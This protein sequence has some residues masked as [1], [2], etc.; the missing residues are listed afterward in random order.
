MAGTDKQFTMC[1]VYNSPK[2]LFHQASCTTYCSQMLVDKQID[3]E[4]CVEAR[5]FCQ[6]LME[7]YVTLLD[8][9]TYMP[10]EHI[11]KEKE[12]GIPWRTTFKQEVLALANETHRKLVGEDA[13][14]F[15]A[16]SEDPFLFYHQIVKKETLD[17]AT[18]DAKS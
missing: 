14:G 8:N 9:A 17:A 3:R 2:E 13:G 10:I 11:Q 6:Q 1:D 4:K 15:Q 16:N 7:R 12:Y 18:F 5:V